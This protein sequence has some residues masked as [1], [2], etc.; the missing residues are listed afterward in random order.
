VGAHRGQYGRFLRNIGYRGKIVSFE[1]EPQNYARLRAIASGDARWLTVPAALGERD[2]EASFNVA[3]ISTFSSFLEPSAYSF[4]QFGNAGATERVIRVPMRR[5][6][7]VLDELITSADSHALFLKMDTQG[8]DS[9]VLDGAFGVLEAV[10]GIQT[11][12]SVKALYEGMTS[13]DAAI[14]RMTSL[15]FELTGLFPVTRDLE[16]RVVEFDCVVRRVGAAVR[17]AT[18]ASA[19]AAAS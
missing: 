11:E 14:T 13:F 4:E 16:L 6:D 17:H 2:G 3:H 19:V 5:L 1:P 9:S 15:G 7:S 18:V 10:R 12:V 8:Y